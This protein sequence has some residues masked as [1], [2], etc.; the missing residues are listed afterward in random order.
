MKKFVLALTVTR[1]MLAPIILII[2]IFFENYWA[3]FLLFNIAALT[4]YFDGKLA[5][6]IGVVSSFGKEIDSLAD[7]VSFCLSPSFLVFN[8]LFYSVEIV[9]CSLFSSFEFCISSKRS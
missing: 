3:A 9:F 1:I 7:V 5:R 6:K 2:S 8:I 4:D